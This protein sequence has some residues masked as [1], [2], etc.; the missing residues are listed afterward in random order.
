[1]VNPVFKGFYLIFALSEIQLMFL[2][3][4]PDGYFSG[5]GKL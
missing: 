5:A 2:P 1:M 3:I 4:A